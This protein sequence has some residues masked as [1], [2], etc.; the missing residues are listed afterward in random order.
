MHLELPICQCKACSADEL[1]DDR[2]RSHGVLEPESQAREYRVAA[3]G[4]AATSA[5]LA[6]NVV[7]AMASD[8]GQ[9]VARRM[10][11]LDFRGDEAARERWNQLWL[12]SCPARLHFLFYH[13]HFANELPGLRMLL[14]GALGCPL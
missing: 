3:G 1:P 6:F 9:A 14:V 8:A 12:V 10:Q 5:G 4:A 11:S 2:F 13:F 7:A